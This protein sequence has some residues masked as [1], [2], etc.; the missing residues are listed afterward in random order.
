MR[1]ALLAVTVLLGSCV[2]LDLEGTSCNADGTCGRGLVCVANRCVRAQGTDGGVDAGPSTDAGT[3]DSGTSDA[4]ASDAGTIDDAGT[5]DGGP[6]D[7]GA[8]AGVMRDAGEPFTLAIEPADASCFV[9]GSV[10]FDAR[11]TG[12][13]GTMVVTS[14]ASWS[15]ERTSYGTVDAGLVH[16]LGVGL[17]TLHASYLG[18]MADAVI[19][20]LPGIPSRLVLTP[21]S[22]DLES[23][24]SQRLNVTVILTNDAGVAPT[25]VVTWSTSD[26]GIATVDMTGLVH[27]HHRGNARITVSTAGLTTDAPVTVRSLPIVSLAVSPPNPLI[28]VDFPAQLTAMAQLVDGGAL[29]V[30]NRVT[31]TSSDP[32][33]VDFLA[34]PGLATFVSA[35]NSATLTAYEEGTGLDASI[36]IPRRR[37]AF[38]TAGMGTGDLSSWTDSMGHTGIDAGDAIC[39]AEAQVAGFPF[40]SSFRA[41]LSTGTDDAYCR[42]LGRSGK[43]STCTDGGIA[44]PWIRPDGYPFA[45]DLATLSRTGLLSPP[46]VKPDSVRLFTGSPILTGT[47]SG[48]VENLSP[49]T[50]ANWTSAS[51]TDTRGGVLSSAGADWSFSATSRC[52]TALH[53]LLCFEAGNTPDAGA[54]PLLGHPG[55]LVF[56]TSM[57]GNGNL[58][59]WDGGLGMGGF[60]GGDGI[61]TTLGRRI[62]GR[63]TAQYRVWLSLGNQ[64]A[65]NR[66][67]LDAGP[68]VRP[69]G[70]FVASTLGAMANE[71][72]FAPIVVDDTSAFV[73]PV[74]PWM[75]T[76][77]GQQTCNGW[78][79]NALIAATGEAT[80]T[81]PGVWSGRYPAMTNCS[82]PEPLICLE[83]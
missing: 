1:R 73:G 40:A 5:P 59:A 30:T 18:T 13:S 2:E 41:W 15:I 22:L 65:A 10:Q 60:D 31:W 27:A 63:G 78:E 25:T 43:V 79:S 23:G 36:V 64:P 16:C 69:D 29:D 19:N 57:R 80:S 28:A 37:L 7:A 21:P 83:Q 46:S 9:G 49:T 67:N 53:R 76:D 50:C 75:G 47:T 45:R 11:A 55:K 68:W 77:M 33:I 82:L 12:D 74:T 71:D 58:R 70:V 17:T 61:C 44:G 6:A 26:A 4:G 8:D 48:G 35:G 34:T 24:D 3:S 52:D 62:S 42:V 32:V 51:M 38:V 81:S 20:I 14:L 54:L 66:F 72:L 39:Q 56:V